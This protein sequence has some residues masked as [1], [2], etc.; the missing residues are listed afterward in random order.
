M[1]LNKLKLLRFISESYPHSDLTTISFDSV[2]GEIKEVVRK[3][4]DLGYTIIVTDNDLESVSLLNKE[5]FNLSGS[6]YRYKYVS[7]DGVYRE[8]SDLLITSF[9]I[10]ESQY[11]KQIIT[12]QSF[13]NVT[14]LDN[15]EP[16][17]NSEEKE[18]ATK[19]TR[20]NAGR[21]PRLQGSTT[22]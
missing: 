8:P 1:K 4:F 18:A 22:T 20:K 21:R 17:V 12:I 10:T 13:L 2:E 19:S 6:K 5:I 3:L 11:A 16:E 14:K 7:F 9:N 15:P